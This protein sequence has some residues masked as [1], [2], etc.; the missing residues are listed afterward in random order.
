MS[1]PFDETRAAVAQ[2]KLQLE[3]AD[4][5]ANSMANLL[6]GRLRKVWNNDHLAALKRELTD[7]NIQTRTWKPLGN[8]D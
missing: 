7:Y 2:A 3:A 1:N 6:Q 8:K 4:A 5:V